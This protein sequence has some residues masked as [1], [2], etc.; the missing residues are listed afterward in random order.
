MKTR[1]LMLAAA[2]L[3]MT[4]A[5]VKAA[6]AKAE[7]DKLT[8]TWTAVSI[9]RDGTPAS[10][11][12]VAKVK[13]VVDGESYVYHSGDDKVEG[14]HM[15]DPSK[16]P[17]EIDAVRSTGPDAGK[18]IRGIYELDG[19]QFRVCLGTP[20]GERPTEFSTKAGSGHRLLV[21]KR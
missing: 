21:F 5:A 18:T 14:K 2:A 12:Q 1:V 9:E 20:G 10:S 4:A 17:K 13:L 3:A 7:L 6:D 19:D 16:S 8:G 15:L 11:D